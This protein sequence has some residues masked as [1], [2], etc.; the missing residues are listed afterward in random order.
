MRHFVRAAT[1]LPILLLLSACASGRADAV[2]DAT[3]TSFYVRHDRL[4][5]VIVF[6]HGFLGD[7]RKT[8][9]H[10]NGAYWPEMLRDDP[11]FAESD[12]YVAGFPTSLWDGDNL[13]IEELAD[14]M[15]LRLDADG[16]VQEHREIVFLCH[17]LGGLVTRSYLLRYRRDP[18]TV[19]LLVLFATP[20][21][22]SPLAT[23]GALASPNPILRQVRPRRSDD[24][25]FL[26]PSS[27]DWRES[28]Y[29]GRT[30]T[31]C[32]YEKEDIFG[33]HIVSRNSA[34][35]L[36]DRVDPMPLD[37]VAMV[38]PSSTRDQPYLAFRQAYADAF[39]RSA[40]PPPPSN[41]L[42]PPSTIPNST[43][44]H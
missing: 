21:L 12:I 8:W 31:I 33:V 30:R 9:T 7:P 34:T 41:E 5:R 6:V 17:S 19:P 37:H 43:L 26:W 4:P 16:V 14:Y 13:Q 23:P 29:Y 22:G 42:A 20:M 40:V 27:V 44:S 36:C 28:A 1:T 11:F 38:K 15:R 39:K 2:A 32:S 35:D 24:A 3:P 18:A 25:G 10:R